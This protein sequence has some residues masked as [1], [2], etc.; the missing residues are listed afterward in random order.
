M[1]DDIITVDIPQLVKKGVVPEDATATPEYVLKGLTFYAGNNEI[2]TGTLDLSV[3]N[4]L[5]NLGFTKVGWKDGTN[6]VLEFRNISDQSV[7]EIE[8]SP[9]V[10]EQADLS[11][12]DPTLETF[13]KNK[14]TK[15]LLNEGEDGSSK[16]ATEK[17][18]DDFGGKIDNISVNDELLEIVDKK[19][20]I[21]VPTK[22]NQLEDDT[23]HRTVTDEI[24]SNI[25]SNTNARHTHENKSVLDEITG[26][27][28]TPTEN[29]TNLL[30]SGAIYSAIKGIPVDNSLSLTSENA[31]QNKVVA[32]A[33]NGVVSILEGKTNSYTISYAENPLFNSLA[34]TVTLNL[35]E[36]ITDVNKRTI[37]L[38][39]L[40]LGD[41]INVI[42]T[43]VVDRW[44]GNIT[45]T[46]IVFYTYESKA[47]LNDYF[48]K[49]E[50]KNL[51]NEKQNTLPTTNIAGKVLKSTSTAG[52]LEWTDD[53]D[54]ITTT[55]ITDYVLSASKWNN[56]TYTLEVAGKT[57][58]NNARVSNSNTGT[59]EE[60][61]NNAN[62][63]SDANIYKITDN[64]K[65][66]TFVCE[67]TPTTD[68]K[69]QVEVFE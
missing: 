12:D 58:S 43:N 47:N 15:Y 7:Q 1:A 44:V 42:E 67:T 38:N 48:T 5:A 2:K 26:F 11:I 29:S 69:I 16:Y 52:V 19:V 9:F 65:T 64:G 22:L 17:Y 39:T 20:N 56:N 13:V 68:L 33:L 4:V 55:L 35:N 25:E 40:K 10:Q 34:D 37:N 53:K 8:L 36:I 49:N 59:D 32:E 18:V 24:L 66:L 45:S 51:L 46:D 14:S 21:E 62:A 41:I 23:Q 31:I 63:I 61:L 27:D 6:N 50:T 30:K 60:V 57:S 54:T 3:I 28:N